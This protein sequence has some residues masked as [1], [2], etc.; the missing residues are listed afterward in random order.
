MRRFR[1]WISPE[2]L[3]RPHTNGEAEM[4]E[5]FDFI[6]VGGG[7]AGAVIA[8]RLS[9]DPSCRVALIEAGER[10]PEISALPIAP[11]AM[12]LNP[13]TDWMYTADPGKAGLGLNG[14]RMPVPRGKMLGGSSGINYM[15]YVR[16]NPGDFDA[17]SK[18]GATGWSYAEVLPYFKKSEGLAPSTEIVIDEA[19]H[20]TKG[21][22]GVSVRDP[23]LPAARQF[24]EAAVAAG[25]P[26][27]DY[28]GRDR[29]A[30]SGVA[31]LTQFT[32]RN[33]RRSSTYQAFLAGEP[34]RRSNLTIITGARATRVLLVG[35]GGRTIAT[36][37]EYQNAVG[38]TLSVHATKEVI[39]SAGAIGSPQLLLLSGIGPRREL[40]A[41]GISCRV[42]APHVGKHLQDHA[43]CPLIYPAPGLGVAMN[44]VALAMGPDA[45]RA[46]GG[47]LPADPAEDVNLSPELLALKQAAEQRL[48][49]WQASGRGL[50]ASSLADAAVF[51]SSGLGD[52]GRHDVEIIFF[53]TGTNEDF[54]R[55]ILNIDTALFF[56][57]ARKCVAN[58]AENLV[59]FP[60][61]VLPH[62]R[63]EIVL[64]SA[65]PAAPPAIHMNYYDDP[66]DM[67]VMVAAI[68]RAMDIAAHW[69]GNRRPGPVMI[70]PFLAEK[71]GYREGGAPSDALL[72]EFAQHF[73]LTVYHP[74]STCRIGD[75]VD[76]RLR[77]LGV[78]RLRVADASVMPAVIGGNTNAPTIMIGEKAAEMIAVEHGVRLAEF[79]G[80]RAA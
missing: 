40:E 33:G 50:G 65:D 8:S 49:E 17:W 18:G 30:P 73:S 76:P 78:G 39:L 1:R 44:D 28:N 15:M 21:P 72:E 2:N 75:V 59:L 13:A 35:E 3:K 42:N 70:P 14:R 60:H 31:S 11:A 71:H 77:V 7:S 68:R 16:G 32:T 24:V 54:L 74:T 34:E 69:P 9:E 57:D 56:D 48:A 80:E 22:L 66:H 23:I 4:S 51:C 47:P 64:D 26:R 53:V 46:P 19:A 5:K 41:A 63:G 10:P 79:V 12:Q 45:L 62:S 58:D 6:V 29:N 36:G 37:V 55:M 27:G 43:M 67:R 61:P 38:E 52:A 20:S 25:I